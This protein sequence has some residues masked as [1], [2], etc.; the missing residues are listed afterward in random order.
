MSR[1]I[2]DDIS[3]VRMPRLMVD[4]TYI[5]VANSLSIANIIF[6]FDQW[7]RIITK[8]VRLAG[9]STCKKT[10]DLLHG[11][12]WRGYQKSSPVSSCGFVSGFEIFLQVWVRFGLLK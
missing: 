1:N 10:S 5:Y 9:R 12:D 7:F 8:Q 3:Y 4:T 2:F 6:A 11:S